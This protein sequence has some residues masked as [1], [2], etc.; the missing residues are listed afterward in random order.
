MAEKSLFAML[1]RSPWWIS[2]VVVGIIV[3]AARALLPAEYFVVGAL[4]GFPSSWWAAWRPG[5]SCRPPT[6]PAWPK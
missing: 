4:A 5:A 3:L 1:L 6:R 2:F